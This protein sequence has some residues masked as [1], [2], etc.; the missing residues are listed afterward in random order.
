MKYILASIYLAAIMAIIM[1]SC[2]KDKGAKP[3]PT[4][5]F[6]PDYFIFGK[7]QSMCEMCNIVGISY[8]MINDKKLYSEYIPGQ[9]FSTANAMPDSDYQKVQPLIDQFPAYFLSH[10]NATIGGTAGGGVGGPMNI[11]AIM[12]TDTL[13]WYVNTNVDSLPA[14]IKPYMSQLVSTWQGLRP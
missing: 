6:H 2:E 5:N 10:T 7:D 3:H 1:P 4:S 13:K 8:Y 11:I 12:G 9:M 14:E